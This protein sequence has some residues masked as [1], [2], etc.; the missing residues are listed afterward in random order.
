MGTRATVAIAGATGFVGRA[1]AGSLVADYKV[2]GLSRVPPA[3]SDPI[4]A[5]PEEPVEWR[6]CDLFSLLQAE[7]ALAGAQSAFYLVHSMLSSARLTQG[8]FQDMDLVCADNFARAVAKAGVGQIVY[9]GGLIP[10]APGLSRHLQ[11]R[12]EVE[13]TLGSRGV[14]VTALR[15]GII[16]GPGGSSY[17]I[18]RTL[19]ERVPVIPCPSW[20]RSLTQPVALDDVLK[21][22]RYCLEHPSPRSR[23]FDIGSPDVM[24]YRKLLER[25]ARRLGLERVFVGVPAAGTFWFSRWLSLVSGAPQALVAP[26]LE[27]VKHSMVCRDRRL[28]EEAE[29]PGI[30]FDVAVRAALAREKAM[31]R[32]DLPPSAPGRGSWRALYRCDVRSVQRMV[33]PPGKS[34]RWAAERYSCWLPRI[35]CTFL[36]AEAD[37]LRNVRFRLLFPRVTLLELAF[38]RDRSQET[39]RQVFYITGGLLARRIVRPTGRPRLEFREVLGGAALLVAIHDYRPTLPWPLYNATQALVHLWV[40]RGFA[41]HLSGVARLGERP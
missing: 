28:Q 41:R 38:A 21:L 34:A 3:R 7:K 17:R 10:D 26:L 2:V 25:T 22:L 1:L 31:R 30:P 9:L 20:T 33:L 6:R 36:R 24:S 35:F 14:P 18:F 12:L 5:A 19:V 15:A 37:S 16:I 39:D 23:S 27:S 11:S 29:V 13:A 4:P 8:S 32:L 40:M